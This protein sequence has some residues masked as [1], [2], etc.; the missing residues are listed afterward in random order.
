MGVPN[1]ISRRHMLAISA[2]GGLA[3]AT[4]SGARAQAP[5]AKRIE[6]FDPAL[7]KIVS[8]TEPIKDIAFGFGGPLGSA[9]RLRNSSHRFLSFAAGA[10]ASCN[11]LA[12]PLLFAGAVSTTKR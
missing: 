4:R 9:G 2:A 3:V 11:Y 8:T 6:Q 1:D 5:T 7:E 12:E 10:L